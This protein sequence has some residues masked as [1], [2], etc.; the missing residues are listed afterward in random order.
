MIRQNCIL[1]RFVARKNFRQNNSFTARI[2]LL[3]KREKW[4]NTTDTGYRLH[5]NINN[6]DG[7]DIYILMATLLN[8]A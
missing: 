7:L 1:M 8:L 5:Q 4:W 6:T 2:N 3:Y